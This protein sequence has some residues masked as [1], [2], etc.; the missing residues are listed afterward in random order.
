MINTANALKNFCLLLFLA[1][2]IVCA[3]FFQQHMLDLISAIK[4]LGALAPLLF[5]VLYCLATVLI[6]PTMVLTL[7]GG[8][9]FGPFL[10]TLLNLLGATWGAGCAFLISRYLAYN[11]FEQRRGERL[12]QLIAGVDKRG[13]PFVAILRLLPII[14]FSLVNYGLGITGIRFK[15]YLLTTFIFLIPAE[16]IYTYCG[17]AGIKLLT[18]P[19]QIYRNIGTAILVVTILLLLIAKQLQV[20]KRR[21][22][23]R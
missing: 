3:W 7:A 4:S 9:I 15:T 8:A 1:V 12:N 19:D 17:H 18:S 21:K 22:T 13:W 20:R 5:L 2:F 14:P 6:L 10:G 23:N 11:W 16:I